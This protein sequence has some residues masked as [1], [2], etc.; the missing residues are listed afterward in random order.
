MDYWLFLSHLQKGSHCSTK[1]QIHAA[2]HTLTCSTPGDK[3]RR[4]EQVDSWGVQKLA[5]LAAQNVMVFSTL[6]GNMPG[7]LVCKQTKKLYHKCTSAGKLAQTFLSMLIKTEFIQ[8]ELCG[9]LRI[10]IKPEN[11]TEPNLS[12]QKSE[13]TNK[14]VSFSFS[15][16]TTW[17][18]MIHHLKVFQSQGCVL[19]SDWVI[20]QQWS[21]LIQIKG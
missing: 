18:E 16:T 12:C 14:S 5:Q 3:E 21:K 6:N 17:T 8:E 1:I 15:A 10:W 9:F 19:M 4:E 2:S 20:E 13:K 11:L 7:F